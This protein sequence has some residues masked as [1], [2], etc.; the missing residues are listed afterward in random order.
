VE[1]RRAQVED[2]PTLTA[3]LARAFDDDPILRWVFPAGRTRDRYGDKFFRWSLWRCADQGVTWTTGDLSGAAIW[4]LHDR[5][6]V[7]L[8][9]L[10]RLFLWAGAG[11]R[12]RGPRV[13][14]GLA[15]IERRQPDD[16]HMYL[17]VLGVEPERQG[18]GLG[19]ALLR[20]GLELCDREALPAYLETGNER[21]LSFYGRHGF[22][23]IGELTLP[24]GPPVWLMRREP[25]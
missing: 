21:N 22:G 9:Q 19:S 6:R 25:R 8:P 10:A 15:A 13:M 16:R 5:W 12:L 24:K 4:A 20:P 2:H 18:S 23:V 3:M 14:W 7:T 17:A 11:V 1:V